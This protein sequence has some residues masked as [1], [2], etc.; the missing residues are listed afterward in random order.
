M[1]AFSAWRD[2]L[3]Q[4]G[5][6]ALRIDREDLLGDGGLVALAGPVVDHRIFVP[7]HVERDH[8]RVRLACAEL[9][10]CLGRRL[11]LVGLAADWRVA[12]YACRDLA[13][14]AT[15]DDGARRIN[16]RLRLR[17]DLLRRVQRRDH[18]AGNGRTGIGLVRSIDIAR[19]LAIGHGIGGGR[20]RRRSHWKQATECREHRGNQDQHPH[21]LLQLLLA[22]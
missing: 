7:D 16:T 1:S 15:P 20:I 14:H 10:H 2:R 5:G 21:Q 17:L 6:E 19:R 8:L 12:L 22:R 11:V 3:P 9:A 4:I 13:S 18:P